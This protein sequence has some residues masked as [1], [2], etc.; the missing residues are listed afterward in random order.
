MA[1][2]K[3]LQ[4]QTL[5]NGEYT[6]LWE[7]MV[8]EFTGYRYAVAVAN[9]SAG[10]EMVMST[11]RTKVFEWLV[12]NLTFVAT[13]QAVVKNGIFP[14]FA[15]HDEDTYNTEP[16]ENNPYSTSV[17]Y[18]GYPVL[19]ARSRVFDS[20]HYVWEGMAD[21]NNAD[22]A[23]LSHHAVKPIPAGEGG[24]IL[25]NDSFANSYLRRVRSHGRG[26]N[27]LSI[28]LGSNFR[29]TEMQ[30]AMLVARLPDW[31]K[32]QQRRTEIAEYYTRRLNRHSLITPPPSH[33]RHAWHL[34]AV[35]IPKPFRNHIKSVLNRNGIETAVH[36]PPVASHPDMKLYTSDAFLDYSDTQATTEQFYQTELS[37]PMHSGL[38]DE[39]VEYVLDTIDSTMEK[40]T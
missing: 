34:Y 3:V 30:A 16:D 40:V 18:G 14:N 31:E 1:V 29:M 33:E 15:A 8:A 11:Y 10:L 35:R 4:S 32:E 7:H 39:E 37:L 21:D 27:G 26:S 20:A 28:Y 12:P 13:V 17:S 22:F 6:R 24:T 5:T 25:T 2:E 38:T 9:A 23:V 36:Y 19:N